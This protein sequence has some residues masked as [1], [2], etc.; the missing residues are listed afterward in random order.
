MNKKNFS[1]N[2]KIGKIFCSSVQKVA[3]IGVFCKKR[4]L[5][6]LSYFNILPQFKVF[7]DG[8]RNQSNVNFVHTIERFF[9]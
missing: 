1:K 5:L 2:V 9:T 4:T 7:V 8:T 3:K 6:K